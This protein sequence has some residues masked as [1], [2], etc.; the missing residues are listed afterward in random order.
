MLGTLEQ[1]EEITAASAV[2][3]AERLIGS[4]TSMIC[5]W[6]NYHRNGKRIVPNV[7][8]ND[9]TAKAF[10]KMLRQDDAEPDAL[11]EHT[12]DA[13]LVLYA[14]HDLAASTFAARTT[15]ST[16]S[17]SYSAITT[18]IGTLRGPLHGGANEAVM[19]F[20][21]P[22]ATPDEAE[23]LLRQRLAAKN[24]I[25]GFGHRVYKHGDPR[26][27]VF[28]SLSKA[29]SQRPNGRPDLY[30]ISERIEE[31]MEREKGMYANADFYAASS[32]HQCGIPTELFTPIFVVS[33]TSGWAAHIAEQR[34][35]NRIIRPSS[36]YV[37]HG[38]R[39]FVPLAQRGDTPKASL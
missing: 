21:E 13:S 30:A 19:H 17:D 34:S 39:E 16:M 31:L 9:G 5:Y 7:D 24:L 26:N 37:G 23:A 3:V 36:L 15:A 25:M 33:R 1:E 8:S 10:L 38:P 29:L 22:L 11:E 14:E 27:R 18:A 12:V 35:N 28:K 20:L 4:F 6:Y 2:A 32:Y